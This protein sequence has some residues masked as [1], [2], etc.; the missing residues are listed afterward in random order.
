[1]EISWYDIFRGS[2]SWREFSV[3][4]MYRHAINLLTEWHV[5][6]KL[7]AVEKS[8][9]ESRLRTLP[10]CGSL[11]AWVLGFCGARLLGCWAV[12]LLCCRETSVQECWGVEVF[13]CWGGE[14][15][16]LGYWAACLLGCWAAGVLCC[17]G[18]WVL[19]CRVL[20][21]GLLQWKFSW[22]IGSWVASRDAWVV[23]GMRDDLATWPVGELDCCLDNLDRLLPISHRS[24]IYESFRISSHLA[25]KL[26]PSLL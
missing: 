17:W 8:L 12:G 23:V 25:S 24:L 3:Y 16:F 7:I 22:V 20:R 10:E 21:S 18:A 13:D 9:L 5:H 19:E 6:G 4:A 14:C 15:S 1:M 2:L 26:K 11:I